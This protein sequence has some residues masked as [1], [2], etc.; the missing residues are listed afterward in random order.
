MDSCDWV[1]GNGNRYGELVAVD[2]HT[3]HTVVA[4]CP[5]SMSQVAA[6]EWRTERFCHSKWRVSVVSC[7]I[8]HNLEATPAFGQQMKMYSE[9]AERGEPIFHSNVVEER[10][11]LARRLITQASAQE[12]LERD[13][14]SEVISR[15]DLWSPWLSHSKSLVRWKGQ[16]VYC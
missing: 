2:R 6:E 14:P 10:D 8:V 3:D 4:P 11:Q 15:I 12:V 13:V 7:E 9:L 16:L 5:S 1:D